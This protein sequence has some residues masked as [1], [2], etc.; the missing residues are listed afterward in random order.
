MMPSNILSNESILLA[1]DGWS[2]LSQMEPVIEAVA[3][4]RQGRP[5]LTNVRI[6]EPQHLGET[7]YVGT[8]LAFGAFSSLTSLLTADGQRHSVRMLANSGDITS[9]CFE[10][11][12]HFPDFVQP[13]I[14]WRKISSS[15]KDISAHSTPKTLV[16]RSRQNNDL[17]ISSG[18]T[19]DRISL[20]G[21]TFFV[22]DLSDF[23]FV[24]A[25]N[26]KY[27]VLELSKCWEFVDEETSLQID[28]SSYLVATWL[29]SAS[30]SLGDHRR[31]KYDSI[32]HTACVTV[33]DSE[34]P[35]LP[36]QRAAC[37]FRGP[38]DTPT[39]RIEWEDS[40]VTLISAGFLLA[41]C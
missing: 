17:F 21:Q 10:N 30:A 36:L 31:F 35:L 32:Q 41:G 13:M 20:G 40:S 33:V 34:E 11:L 8:P 4:D 9:N 3:V 22:T 19:Q 23:E 38:L 14:S 28:R 5:V 27:A 29:M 37:A 16:L 39:H 24:L 2:P 26:W 15:L 1:R 7:F 12:I 18:R 25:N 6:S